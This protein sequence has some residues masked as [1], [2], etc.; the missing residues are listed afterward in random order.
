MAGGP[1]LGDV[2]PPSK[3]GAPGLLLLETWDYDTASVPR[4]S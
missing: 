1:G 4:L 3:L 2:S